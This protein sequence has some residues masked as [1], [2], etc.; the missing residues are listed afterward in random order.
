MIVAVI[1]TG[2]VGSAVVNELVRNHSIDQ[3]AI[4]DRDLEKAIGLN[5]DL[6][7]SNPDFKKKLCNCPYEWI[8]DKV[9]IV[10]LTAGV[11]QAKGQSREELLEKN[12]AITTD[13]LSKIKLDRQLLIVVTNP[14]DTIALNAMR[15]TG[16]PPNKVIGFGGDLDSI[17]LKQ[18]LALGTDKEA[19]KIE[20]HVIG[21]HG[22]LAVPIYKNPPKWDKPLPVY[23][24]PPDLVYVKPKE[25][26][27]ESTTASVRVFAKEIIER[28]DATV[29]G[30]A[31]RIG[32]LVDDI[33]HNRKRV[34]DVSHFDKGEGVFVTWPCK[35]GKEGVIKP[36]ELSLTENE[37][38]S[39]RKV[40]DHLKELDEKKVRPQFS[41]AA[42]KLEA[43]LTANATKQGTVKVH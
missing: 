21:G 6:I 8:N 1:G 31:G 23:F 22:E 29:F 37:R 20:A 5:A 10:I 28:H 32:E 34:H 15:V 42:K 40:V 17:R 2:R 38:L 18:L 9:D 3:V 7:N 26:T 39:Y 4:V 27:L 13:I 16:L 30:P 36:I 41:E 12:L 33:A 25:A 11:A 43:G 19:K 24:H 35:I 14:V